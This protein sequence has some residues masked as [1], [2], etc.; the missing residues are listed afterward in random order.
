MTVAVKAPPAALIRVLNPIMRAVLPTRLGRRMQPLAILEITG[1]RTGREHR[2]PVGLHD[3]D[4]EHVIFTDRPWR[5]NARGGADVVVAAGGRRR[6]GYAELIDDPV[7]VGESLAAAVGQVGPRRL[8]LAVTGTT[9]TTA[10][11]AATGKS[12]IRIRFV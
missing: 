3:V 11:Y 8:G 2:I 5:E 1:H 7:T 6:P 9:P 4:G 10:D 12:M